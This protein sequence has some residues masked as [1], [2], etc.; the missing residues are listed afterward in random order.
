MATQRGRKKEPANSLPLAQ[1]L[2]FIERMLHSGR[3]FSQQHCFIRR[4]EIVATDGLITVGHPI[5]TDLHAY[6]HSAKLLAA[7]KRCDSTVGLTMLDENRMSIK[8][9]K[10]KCTLNCLPA[11][12]FYADPPNPAIAQCTNDIRDGFTAV[13]HIAKEDAEKVSFGSILM[14]SGT[15]CVT[16]GVVLLEYWHG[17]DFP[18]NVVL[19]VK[20]AKAVI[21]AGKNLSKFGFSPGNSVTFYF[22]DG[23]WVRS[24]LFADQWPDYGS[25]FQGQANPWPTPAGFFDAT[26]ALVPFLADSGAVFFNAGAMASHD[27]A[28][29]GATYEVAGLPYGPCYNAAHLLSIERACISI[30]WRV[31]S[32]DPTNDK[33]QSN[34]LFFGEKIRGAIAPMRRKTVKENI[35]NETI[36]SNVKVMISKVSGITD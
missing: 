11:G 17:N 4:E 31:A 13:Q 2:E 32:G 10:F 22:E 7:L 5:Q 15:M 36:D 34:A 33:G 21:N 35:R 9:G 29:T 6:P 27:D 1:A 26:R 30:D 20:T 12:S 16:N 23:S 8:S 3:S 28:D 18:P 24:Q 25:V 19:P 14:N